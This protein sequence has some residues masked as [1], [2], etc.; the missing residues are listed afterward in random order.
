MR[1]VLKPT[2]I[3]PLLLCFALSA[4]AGE[5]T[6]TTTPAASSA[7]QSGLSQAQL[8]HGIGP[9][10][11]FDPGPIDASL[12]ATGLELY[13]IKCSACHKMGERYVGPDL[14]LVTDTRS[15]AYVMNMILNP[16]EMIQ[17]HPEAR[18][19]FAQ[20]MTPM[21]NQSLTQ[22]EARAILE[23]LRQVAASN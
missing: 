6:E 19:L 21:A 4:C 12:A 1:H 2:Q 15:P 8:E 9:I 3:I 10:E 18:A 22:D 13:T 23:Y 17:K 16:E 5:S 7:E 14:R 20:F 11:A